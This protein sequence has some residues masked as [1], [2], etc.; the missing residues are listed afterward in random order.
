[1]IGFLGADIGTTGTKTMLFDGNDN[2]VGRGYLGYKL[3]TP[4]NRAYEQDAED[5]YLSLK[6]SIIE[7]TKDSD[8]DI[9]ALS[10][11]SQG[12]SFF[13]A[14]I[15]DGKIVP[16]CRALTWMDVRAGEELEEAKKMML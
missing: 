16:L 12:G 13:L 7:A 10:L 1:M 5:W 6:H 4:F 2:A 15:V 14:D 8:L 9:K 11:S 3:Y